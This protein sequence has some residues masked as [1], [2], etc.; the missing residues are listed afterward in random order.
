VDHGKNYVR[1]RLEYGKKNDGTG[2]VHYL[3]NEIEKRAKLINALLDYFFDPE[4]DEKYI[5]KIK[6]KRFLIPFY[7]Q[8][9]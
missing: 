1:L 7:S 9:Q 4:K 6:E 3:D 8:I 5:E 2:Y